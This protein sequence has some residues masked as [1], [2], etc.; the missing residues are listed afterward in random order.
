LIIGFDPAA[1]GGE[2]TLARLAELAAMV[3]AEPG[4]RLPGSRRLAARRKAA[5]EGLAVP[6]ALLAEIDA[7]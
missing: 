4:A 5:S 3:E 2:H 1:L 7:A 6:D